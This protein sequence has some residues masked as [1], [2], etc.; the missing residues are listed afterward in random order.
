M[1][2]RLSSRW[3]AVDFSERVEGGRRRRDE[4]YAEGQLAGSIDTDFLT[5]TITI[6]NAMED[7]FTNAR[8]APL[9]WSVN[10]SGPP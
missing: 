2:T 1:K 6:I 3:V 7:V 9:R 10:V 5:I 4:R 8:R